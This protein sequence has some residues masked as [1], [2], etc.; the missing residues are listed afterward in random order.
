M[1]HSIQLPQGYI[2]FV[3]DEDVDLVSLTWSLDKHKLR[4][5]VYATR[6]IG[7]RRLNKTRAMHRTILSRMLDRELLRCEDVD[8]RDGNGLNNVRDNLRLANRSQNKMNTPK[9]R[10]AN[11]S[12]IYKGVS[13]CKRDECWS[14]FIRL[15]DKQVYLGRTRIEVIAARL[16]DAA[17]RKHYGEFALTNFPENP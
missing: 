6:R 12:S 4:R 5:V 9:P 8:H 1:I 15:G 13:W 3:S 11:S 14:V 10:Y 17:A 7:E 2:A 16:Y